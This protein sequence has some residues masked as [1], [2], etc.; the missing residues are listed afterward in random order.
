M[1]EARRLSENYATVNPC[2]MCMPMGSVMA[3][4]GIEGCMPIF[5]GSQGC[6]TYMRLHLAHHYREPVDIASSA[7][8][9]KGAV[10]GGAANLKKGLLNVIQGY[11]PKVVGIATT[12]LAETIGDDV[13]QIVRE[14]QQEEPSA[15]E[16][17]I[18]SASTPSYSGSHEEGYNEALKAIVRTLAKRGRPNSRFNLV[19]GSIVSPAEVR[20]IKSMLNEWGCGYD[21]TL[22]PDISETFDAPLA[23]D[24][25]KIPEGGTPL[26]EIAEM[27]N[28]RETLT[29]GGSVLVGGAGDYLEREFGVH[30]TRLPLPIGV[31]LTDRFVGT[32]EEITG[33]GLP[34]KYERDRGR[35]L[36]AI[37][38]CHKL[39][40][41]VRTAVFGDTDMVLGVAKLLCEMGMD[42]R[43]LATGSKNAEFIRWGEKMAP[44]SE[45][46]SGVDFSDIHESVSRN[47][48]DL[49]IGPFTGRQISKAENIPL[50]RVG[51]PNHDRFGA[52]RQM[53]LGYEGATRLVDGI[54]NFIVEMNERGG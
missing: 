7:L 18:I 40:A 24:Y 34:E 30:H 37:I 2:S 12:C 14:F 8:S 29:V 11:G 46:L 38:D 35:L 53:V 52:S 22:L 28:S 6:S 50:L 27:A 17:A 10:Y 19:I 39:V 20:Q 44:G 41:G 25:P 48:I 51:L 49:L 4:K 32:L 9:E 54:A 23:A 36:D 26:A 1:L 5:H 33:L 3:F 16:V 43:V 13:A 42:P 45:V 31:E 15:R 47:D 21:Y